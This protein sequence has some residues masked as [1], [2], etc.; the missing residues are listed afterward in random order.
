M[1]LLPKL[2]KQLRAKIIER[3]FVRDVG[4]LT[5]ANLVAA[6]VSFAQGIFVA[7]WLGPELYGTVA[8]VMTYPGLVFAFFDA[9]SAEA[10]VKYLSEFQARGDRERILALC[11]FG[12]SIDLA[13]ALL[14]FFTVLVTANWAAEEIARNP[15]TVGL[16]VI[17][18]AAF[19]PQALVGT[20]R[21]LLTTLGKFSL[22]AWT[23]VLM[24]FWRSVLVISLVLGGWQIAGVVW[25]GAIA[26]S[27]TGLVYGA[28]AW[29]IIYRHWS[30]FPHQGK[31][32]AIEQ[33]IP[34]IVRFLFYNSLTALLGIISKKLD[35]LILGYFRNPTEVGY[36]KLAKSLTNVVGY[37]VKPLQSVTYPDLA[38]LSSS[39]NRKALGQKVR[40][41]AIKVGL[42][43]GL[44]VLAGALFIPVVL[45]LVVGSNYEGAIRAIQLLSLG[46]ALW[47]TVF[48]LRPLFLAR[49]WLQEWTACTFFFSV[50][51]LIGWLIFVPLWGYLA[52]SAWWSFSTIFAYTI[53]PL[54]ILRMKNLQ[55]ANALNWDDYT[56]Q[57]VSQKGT[58]ATD[59]ELLK[60]YGRGRILDAGCGTGIHIGRL[61]ALS[62]VRAAVGVDLGKPGLRYG[63][64][65]F[66]TVTFIEASLYQLPFEDNHF[67]L[68]YSIDVVEHL[69]TPNL[70]IEE[71]YRTCKPGG[72]VFIQTPNYPI[73][74]VYDT[75]H[76]LR[77]SRKKLSD[78][79]THVYHFNSFSLKKMVR[80]SGLQ[81]VHLSA[82]NLAGDLLLPGAKKLRQ[83]WVGHCLGQ[84]TIII[85]TKV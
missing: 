42:P 10:S 59:F 72:F 55:M 7:R 83:S 9:R 47:L 1:Q 40:R 58:T 25:A 27:V 85:A 11:K 62:E 3:K 71:F 76:W 73:K 81:V 63:K 41:L 19:I 6:I 38:K 70:A 26:T 49:A 65:N 53:P 61:A 17:Y 36:Y 24:T 12:Y 57:L 43:L 23:N 82:R 79:P 20:S 34:Q 50:C 29:G 2:W 13:I 60:S 46:F 66:P 69:S 48:W 54:V 51:S 75:W 35:L 52:M 74:R 56:A 68:V 8:L 18:A 45:P 64:E 37:L 28:I 5:I 39:G 33:E 16:I 84:K 21:A 15:E 80:A 67:D 31:W 44:V 32:Q 4:V 77:R 14:A 30:A 22:I 78:D